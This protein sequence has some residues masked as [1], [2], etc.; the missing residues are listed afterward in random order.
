MQFGNRED[1]TQPFTY[2]YSYNQAGRVISQ[3][4]SLR[5]EQQLGYPQMQT[6]M[7][8]TATYQWD[9][10]GRMTQIGYPAVCWPGMC[11]P[12]APPTGPVYD[13]QY[14]NLGWLNGMAP[15][16]GGGNVVSAGY[17]PA[18]QLLNLSYFGMTETRTYNSLL[19]L[20][21]MT[22]NP[23][24]GG[25]VM[26]M[27]YNYSSTQNNG[28]ITSSNDYVTGENVTY[29]YDALNRLS[30]ASAGSMWGEAYSYDGF[31]NLLDKT[32][33]CSATI[34]SPG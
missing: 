8:M 4:M 13:M 10:E 34:R 30:A 27:Q 15:D 9:N 5:M 19:Q 11:N 25:N 32:V 22:A 23:G 17:G 24:Y 21:R 3:S 7:N 20:T 12:Y 26:D 31:G 6:G 28:R 14:D 16:G 18:G 1:L 29:T 2:S 33:T